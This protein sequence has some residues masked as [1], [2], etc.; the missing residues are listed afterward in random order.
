MGILMLYILVCI[1]IHVIL[2]IFGMYMYRCDLKMA[3]LC[4]PTALQ[5]P[6]C[7]RQLLAH[8]GPRMLHRPY[9]D[10]RRIGI[11]ARRRVKAVDRL[12]QAETGV[13]SSQTDS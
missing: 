12:H 8:K 11:V 1:C 9:I 3:Y 2:R 5:H 4:D 10:A 6:L 13:S 7:H